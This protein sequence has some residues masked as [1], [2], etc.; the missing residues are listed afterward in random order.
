MQRCRCLRPARSYSGDKLIRQDWACN[1]PRKRAESSGFTTSLSSG[2]NSSTGHILHRSGFATNDATTKA[3][4]QHGGQTGPTLQC[5]DASF[6]N[7]QHYVITSYTLLTLEA[8]KN[9]SGYDGAYAAELR[10]LCAN[11]QLALIAQ[12]IQFCIKKGNYIFSR[13]PIAYHAAWSIDLC[14]SLAIFLLMHFK[15]NDKKIAAVVTAGPVQ[16]C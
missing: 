4:A 5:P 6:V 3:L 9:Q 7:R 16:E 15:F 14:I 11:S 13:V 12:N 1:A 2:W 8:L 10:W